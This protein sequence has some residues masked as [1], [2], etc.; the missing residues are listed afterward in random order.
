M[1]VSG[2][3]GDRG[4]LWGVEESPHSIEHG[5]GEIP[6]WGNPTVGQPAGSGHR[7]K[8]PMGCCAVQ[9]RVKRWCKRPPA[10]AVM[11]AA[12]QPPPGAR[13]SRDDAHLRV[14]RRWLASQ[15]PG[16]PLEPYGDVRPREMIAQA[17]TCRCAGQNAAY[18][19]AWETILTRQLSV[20][21]R[22]NFDSGV[23]HLNFLE[24]Y[25]LFSDASFYWLQ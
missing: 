17:F 14:G 21:T 19:P 9:V 5:A 16:R 4:S 7:N 6:G 18:R 24:S 22:S 1:R 13:P 23:K 2:R 20:D 12:R 3:S 25:P 8:P 10:S 11:W 15:V